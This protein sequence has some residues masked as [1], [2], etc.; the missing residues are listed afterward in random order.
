[1]CVC[2]VVRKTSS[3]FWSFTNKFASYSSELRSRACQVKVVAICCQRVC[4]VDLGPW[5]VTSSWIDECVAAICGN[6][7]NEVNLPL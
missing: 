6:A 3:F 4:D 7:K 2:V 5:L 1:V